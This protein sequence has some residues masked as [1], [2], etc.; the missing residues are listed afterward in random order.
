MQL[1]QPAIVSRR[2]RTT[3]DTVLYLDVN[4]CLGTTAEATSGCVINI[5]DCV[6]P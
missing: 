4:K 6:N 1:V 3:L 5:G 2:L